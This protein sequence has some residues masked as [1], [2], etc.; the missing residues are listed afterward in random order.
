MREMNCR[1]IPHRKVFFTENQY[2]CELL[3]YAVRCLQEAHFLCRRATSFEL[4]WKSIFAVSL[5]FSVIEFHRQT[6]RREK[7]Q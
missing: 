7:A 2:A 4:H 6:E 5:I 1:H 3:Q